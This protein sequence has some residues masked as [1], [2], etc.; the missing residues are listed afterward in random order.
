MTTQKMAVLIFEL[1][2]PSPYTAPGEAA[3]LC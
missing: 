1:F 2:I 3:L